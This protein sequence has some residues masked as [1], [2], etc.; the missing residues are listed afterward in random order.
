[1]VRWPE[2]TQA[3]G[4]TA[5]MPTRIADLRLTFEASTGDGGCGT[6][7][8]LAGSCIRQS[9]LQDGHRGLAGCGS[10]RPDGGSKV[11]GAP[12]FAAR[13][14]FR[15]RSSGLFSGDVGPRRW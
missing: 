11:A 6:R 8:S 15:P 9:V 7:R 3:G 4:W 1:M 13:I 2:R 5:I 12:L 10:D 14:P